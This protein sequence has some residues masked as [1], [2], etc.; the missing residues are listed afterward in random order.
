MEE[1]EDD[2]TDDIRAGLQGNVRLLICHSAFVFLTPPNSGAT[3]DYQVGNR[4]CLQHVV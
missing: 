2:N 3:L 4:K 1:S